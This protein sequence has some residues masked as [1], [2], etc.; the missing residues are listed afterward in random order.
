MKN[1]MITIVMS[2]MLS[3]FV[4]GT[5]NLILKD[6]N[7]KTKIH[8]EGYQLNN[9][10]SEEEIKKEI[11]FDEDSFV[12]VVL[13]F[14]YSMSEFQEIDLKQFV[15]DKNV[16]YIREQQLN[17]A[18]E[19]HTLQNQKIIDDSEFFDY[20]DL[21]FS[22]Y[23]PFGS[24]KYAD[25]YF[26]ENKDRI[27]KSIDENKEI[28]NAFIQERRDI[29]NSSFNTVLETTN[30]FSTWNTGVY[31]GSGIVVG[32]LEG[33]IMDHT[34]PNIAGSNYEVRNEWYYTETVGTHPTQVASIIAGNYGIARNAKILSVELFGDAQSEMDWLLAR[35]VNIVNM[36]FEYTSNIGYYTSDSAYFDY[37]ART[38][39]VTF[40]AATGNDGE[41]NGYVGN[42]ALGYNVIG[43]GATNLNGLKRALYSSYITQIGPIKP[44]LVA[45]SNITFNGF[46][47]LLSG[48]SFSSPVVAG[49]LALAFEIR[50]MLKAYPELGASAIASSAKT[51]KDYEQTLISGLNNE[52]GAGLLDFEELKYLL[53]ND[54]FAANSGSTGIAGTYLYSKILII[55]S[56]QKLKASFF[57]M[58]NSNKSATVQ[59]TDYYLRLINS[60]GVILKST[61]SSSN[62]DVLEYTLA[63]GIYYLK[64]YQNSPN[65]TSSCDFWSLSWRLNSVSSGGTGGGG[66]SGGGGVITVIND[67]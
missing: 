42:P 67:I 20:L 32:V 13:E 22:E 27:F 25:E 61:S 34:H 54:N 23:A 63:P 64:I 48:T 11:L 47:E 57:N 51:M 2:T 46:S 41:G 44:T 7:S 3:I 28:K 14:N 17:E 37:I 26:I 43:V 1:K 52:V 50:P 21:S 6:E 60:S 29:K 55:S 56:P 33:N 16:D 66:N 5:T 15:T 53:L 9:L 19:I 8:Y 59:I 10:S 31:T 62:L 18:K 35:R 30:L 49:A 4:L 58:L 38:E 45:P 39:W 36:S 65:Q 40:V 24:V 12:N